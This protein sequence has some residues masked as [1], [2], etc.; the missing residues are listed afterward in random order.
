MKNDEKRDQSLDLGWTGGGEVLGNRAG[1]GAF[2]VKAG[3][4]KNLCAAGDLTCCGQD[5]RGPLGRRG[6]G[7]GRRVGGFGRVLEL[8][9]KALKSVGRLDLERCEVARMGRLGGENDS[10]KAPDQPLADAY[11]RL[12][13]L[14]FRCVFFRGCPTLRG[15][16]S[17][18]SIW[19]GAWKQHAT[20][21]NHSQSLGVIYFLCLR[22]ASMG[23]GR[24]DNMDGMDGIGVVSH[25]YHGEIGR[26]GRIERQESETRFA[27]LAAVEFG[28]DGLASQALRVRWEASLR[29]SM[30]STESRPTFYWMAC[31][32]IGAAVRLTR[33]VCFACGGLLLVEWEKL[34]KFVAL[35]EHKI[36]WPMTHYPPS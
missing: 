8:E 26:I 36:S 33:D 12:P 30:G 4:G 15:C 31:A 20:T 23:M 27:R 16:R 13:P 32:R 25:G 35:L 1:T 19:A 14:I 6:L 2:R 28:L 29:S 3:S 10:F 9:E 22:T 11:R 18:V 34:V 21:R 5:A 17:P 7:G 24:L